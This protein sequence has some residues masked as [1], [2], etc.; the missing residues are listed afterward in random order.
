MYYAANTDAFID[1]A[2]VN[3]DNEV[4]LETIAEQVSYMMSSRR[5]FVM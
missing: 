1:E 5:L 4:V 2:I 3:A